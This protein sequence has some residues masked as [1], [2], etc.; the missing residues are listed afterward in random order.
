[1]TDETTLPAA[2]TKRAITPA[3][4]D[5]RDQPAPRSLIWPVAWFA[6]A[7]GLWACVQ[8]QGWMPF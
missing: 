1:M 7:A 6:L 2:P 8:A 5:F 4:E 3:P